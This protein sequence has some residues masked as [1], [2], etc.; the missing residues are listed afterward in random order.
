MSIIKKILFTISIVILN[1]SFALAQG[2]IDPNPCGGDA[3][4]EDVGACPVPLDT[5]VYVLVVAALIFGAYRLYKN[6]KALAA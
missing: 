3:D 5:W 4:P 2:D 6:N 1:I